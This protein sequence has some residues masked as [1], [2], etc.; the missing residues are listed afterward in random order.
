MIKGKLYNALKAFLNINKINLKVT[1]WVER[2][3]KGIG[4][5]KRENS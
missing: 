2:A 3:E 4:T 1:E 5:I